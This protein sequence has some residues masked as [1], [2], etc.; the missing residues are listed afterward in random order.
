M[1]IT[2]PFNVLGWRFPYTSN[3]TVISCDPLLHRYRISNGPK[4]NWLQEILLN[5][6]TKDTT[7]Y[8]FKMTN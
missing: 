2:F 3:M 8:L 4:T 7:K 1:V 5:L 6:D